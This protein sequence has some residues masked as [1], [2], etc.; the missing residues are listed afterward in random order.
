MNPLLIFM[1]SGIPAIFGLNINI[2][3]ILFKFTEFDDLV[4]YSIVVNQ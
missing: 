4:I 1:K 3:A 2:M